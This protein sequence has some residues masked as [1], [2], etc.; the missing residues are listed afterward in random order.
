MLVGFLPLHSTLW[1]L[2]FR[3]KFAFLY[4]INSCWHPCLWLGSAALPSILAP[5]M[6]L[7]VINI[8]VFNPQTQAQTSYSF[9]AEVSERCKIN[10]INKKQFIKSLNDMHVFAFLLT[11]S[12]LCHLIWPSSFAVHTAN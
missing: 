11:S 7:C 1:Y 3:R 9:S 5:H 6:T 2:H 12:F 10:L 8:S 4:V